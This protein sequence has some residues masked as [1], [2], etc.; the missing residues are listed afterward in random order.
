LDFFIVDS[1]LPSVASTRAAPAIFAA[2]C[3]R[4]TNSP[5]LCVRQGRSESERLWRCG[6]QTLN[7]K[8]IGD[9]EPD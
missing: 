2:D 9:T 3:L 5:A 4:R 6:E 8:P 1:F 7:T